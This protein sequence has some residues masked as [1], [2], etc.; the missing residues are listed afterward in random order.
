MYLQQVTFRRAGRQAKGGVQL[1]LLL[2]IAGADRAH[3]SERAPVS[4]GQLPTANC[5]ICVRSDP[6]RAE[7]CSVLRN[8][9]LQPPIRCITPVQVNVSSARERDNCSF[10]PRA[11]PEEQTRE[12][13]AGRAI[14]SVAQ[15]AK[16]SSIFS[17][18]TLRKFLW[19]TKKVWAQ[20]AA[21]CLQVAPVGWRVSHLMF[22]LTEETV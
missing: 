7:L 5:Q 6:S 22:Y 14:R 1:P 4:T 3:P 20:L 13:P 19:R 2:A 11:E 8:K 16:Q 10:V 18:L 9:L 12:W 15:R 17:K 21:A